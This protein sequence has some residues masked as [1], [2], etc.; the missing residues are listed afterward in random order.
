MLTKVTLDG[1]M[2]KRFGRHWELNI[3]KP[4][5]A[6]KLIN[7]NRPGL[8][9]W[10]RDN[11]KTYDGYKVICEYYDGRKEYLDKNDY[12]TERS[13]VKSIRFT[14]VI[15]GSGKFGTII[16]GIVLII[17][18]VLLAEFGG[19]LIAAEG[20]AMITSAGVAM[21][22]GGVIQ[23]V[24]SLIMED[25]SDNNVTKNK[26]NHYF[27]G[28]VNTTGQGIPVPLIYG[29]LIVG[30]QPISVDLSVDQTWNPSKS[31]IH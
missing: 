28:P 1:A 16:A 27:D 2:G 31:I 21:A 24:A 26:T 10:I 29:D 7:A 20:A 17:V 19:E 3:Q 23:L 13:A 4:S 5:D 15:S 6:L 18:G 12:V 30:S 25:G 9:Y 22:I 11:L 14:P 8:F